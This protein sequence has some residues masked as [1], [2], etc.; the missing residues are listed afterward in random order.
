MRV[1]LGMEWANDQIALFQQILSN[2]KDEGHTEQALGLPPVLA[3][4]S[5]GCHKEIPEPRQF[6]QQKF[7]F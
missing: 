3:Q 5:L 4:V 2:I 7:I 1:H 6:K